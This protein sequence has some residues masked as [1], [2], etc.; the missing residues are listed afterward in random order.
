MFY[1]TVLLRVDSMFR[2][3][4]A[5]VETFCILTTFLIAFF[6]LSAPSLHSF[7]TSI[8]KAF[9]RLAIGVLH[10]VA[11]CLEV[12]LYNLLEDA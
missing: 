1:E 7:R 8:V 2:H 10:D 11:A 3:L 12:W 4:M 9:L 5:I 6:F